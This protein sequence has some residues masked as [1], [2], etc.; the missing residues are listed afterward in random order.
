MINNS[1][2]S[3]RNIILEWTVQP[4]LCREGESREF[5][6]EGIEF[7]VSNE[8]IRASIK[9]TS[10]TRFEFEEKAEEIV[11]RWISGYISPYFEYIDIGEPQLKLLEEGKKKYAYDYRARLAIREQ[12]NLKVKN[13]QGQVVRDIREKAFERSFK[14]FK[15]SQ[16]DVT[17]RRIT[18]YYRRSQSGLDVVGVTGYL[19]KIVDALEKKF[20]KQGKLSA[21]AHVV[22]ELGVDKYLLD[23]IG[24]LTSNPKRNA[25]HAPSS[26]KEDVRGIYYAELVE[27]QRIAK[28]I[29][30]AYVEWLKANK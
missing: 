3:L 2:E 20:G 21:R 28:E 26:D 18:Q 15:L 13:R 27:A 10:L 16:K 30:L 7:T 22:H 6:E 23:F 1:R 19:Y 29:I 17:L 5:A 24:E 12:V 4:P 14:I 25:R 9:N 8:T 11:E